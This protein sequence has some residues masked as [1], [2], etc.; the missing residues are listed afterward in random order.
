L[1]GVEL[2]GAWEMGV[3][4]AMGRLGLVVVGRLFRLKEML[5]GLEG[6]WGWFCSGSLGSWCCEFLEATND[7]C[8][9]SG[10]DGSEE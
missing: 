3:L 8:V 7:G 5:P 1:R 6:R 9:R 2:G 4:V 10:V